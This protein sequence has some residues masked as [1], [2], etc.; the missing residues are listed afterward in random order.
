[1]CLGPLLVSSSTFLS[2]NSF[3]KKITFEPSSFFAKKSFFERKSWLLSLLR[4]L[5]FLLKPEEEEF[6]F[7]LENVF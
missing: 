3:E 5:R 4:L 2:H 7:K 1:M 6:N